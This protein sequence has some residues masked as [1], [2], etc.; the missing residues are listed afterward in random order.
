MRVTETTYFQDMV[1]SKYYDKAALVEPL[2]LRLSTT[3]AEDVLFIRQHYG[4][5]YS[6]AYIQDGVNVYDKVDDRL[7]DVKQEVCIQKLILLLHH[8]CL[9]RSTWPW[10][11]AQPVSVVA[12]DVLGLKHLYSAVQ[13]L[14]WNFFVDYLFKAK[15]VEPTIFTAFQL[16]VNSNAK[17]VDMVKIPTNR[18]SQA[19][20]Q[21]LERYIL[22]CTPQKIWDDQEG[23]V[24]L[25]QK[26]TGLQ[27]YF[28]AKPELEQLGYASLQQL[29]NKLRIT[30]G[31][32]VSDNY[33]FTKMYFTQVDKLADWSRQQKSYEAIG[34][35]NETLETFPNIVQAS[36]FIAN[37][38][39]PLV[40]SMA[41]YFL[42]NP[43][44]PSYYD[45]FAQLYAK[46]PT[47]Q[48]VYDS[49]S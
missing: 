16:W 36:N 21:A 32:C 27:L 28:I 12:V 15:K 39:D 40:A 33:K 10:I 1:P 34:L 35:V 13:Y 23:V 29:Y 37:T 47:R 19:W 38:A 26:L 46:R 4:F 18:S 25:L 43:S 41:I 42:N 17:V 9:V 20:R 44:E 6:P 3:T 49:L 30:L 45:S 2:E 8:N 48:D 14:N 22:K 5:N 7:V 11:L 24:Q 31:M